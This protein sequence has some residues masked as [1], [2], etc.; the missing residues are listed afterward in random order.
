[1]TSQCLLISFSR[2]YFFFK[3]TGE[4]LPSGLP[5]SC[6]EHST[7]LVTFSRTINK[8]S[9]I[10]EI[11]LTLNCN[12]SIPTFLREKIKTILEF[13]IQVG[14]SYFHIFSY[15]RQLWKYYFIFSIKSFAPPLNWKFHSFFS[16]HSPSLVKV[17]SNW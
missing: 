12:I 14:F 17:D 8:F 5:L 9:S 4:I 3:L 2:L 10:N 15:M 16:I 7:G 13:S 1:M 6:Q 11:H